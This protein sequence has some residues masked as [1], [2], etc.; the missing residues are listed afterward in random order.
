MASREAIHRLISPLQRLAGTFS[1]ASV[2][3]LFPLICTFC[4][5]S[6]EKHNES[7]LLC[8][9]CVESF[10]NE[11]I[12]LCQRCGMPIPEALNS[13]TECSHCQKVRL[14]FERVVTLGVYRDSLREAVIRMKKRFHEPLTV[15]MGRLLADQID[16][17]IQHNP[18][19]LIVPV[20]IHWDSPHLERAQR[21][22]TARRHY[23]TK[24]QNCGLSEAA[25][26]PQKDKET[27]YVKPS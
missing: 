20:P 15:A 12:T 6:L 10:V 25:V 22:G 19:D 5:T 4:A 3:L 11:S 23:A 7:V 16:S 24:A 21:V 14:Q 13:N 9:A 27:R 1:R 17:Q 8:D 2:D 18:P 26:Q